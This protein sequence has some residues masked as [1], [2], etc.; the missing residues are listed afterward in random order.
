MVIKGL[1]GTVC[2]GWQWGERHCKC[3]SRRKENKFNPDTSFGISASAIP[4]WIDLMI[5]LCITWYKSN[6]RFVFRKALKTERKLYVC[7]YV[8]I[9]VYVCVALCLFNNFAFTYLPIS[10]IQFYENLA[11]SFMLGRVRYNAQSY[12]LKFDFR[13]V[14]YVLEES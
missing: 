7:M 9:H 11:F 2:Q 4:R 1:E 10:K 6:L 13:I 3:M 8:W 5:L 12:K 14:L